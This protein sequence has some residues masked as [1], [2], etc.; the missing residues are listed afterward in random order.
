MTRPA[1]HATG[2]SY[3]VRGM[4]LLDDVDI[5]V[6]SGSVT[7]II[8]PNGAGKSTLLGILAGDI[9]PTT[10]SVG[11]GA[12]AL[13]SISVADLA[14]RRS[15]LLQQSA[16]AFSYTVREVVTMGRSAWRST[17]DAA[18]DEAIVESALEQTDI[19]QLA[20]RDVT[21]LSGGEQARAALAR[22]IAQRS[23]IVLLDEPTAALDI[24]HQERVLELAGELAAAGG[25]VAIVM[26]DLDAAATHADHVVILE[27]G[28]VVAAGPP[29]DV[30]TSE[31]L[32]R[33][34]AHAIDVV[35]HPTTGHPLVI[36]ARTRFAR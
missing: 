15:V 20:G 8:G 24:A 2:I 7:A 36:P 3:A 4:R 16:V 18:D 11:L 34:Y 31:I 26:H 35:E 33:V 6:A 21:T 14:R 10:G 1:L 27:R 17:D 9:Q 19:V 13:G 29:A 23:P 25:A 30:M 5:S 12:D 22:V 28:R 32:S